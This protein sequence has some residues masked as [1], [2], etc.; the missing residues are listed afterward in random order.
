MS[1]RITQISKE[2]KVISQKMVEGDFVRKTNQ[3]IYVSQ[4]V[5]NPFS[6]ET[7]ITYNVSGVATVKFEFYDAGFKLVKEETVKV[8][9][10]GKYTYIFKSTGLADG[11]YFYRFTAGNYVE[12]K[13][14]AIVK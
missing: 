4:N 12:V 9:K 7:T 13:K 6:D 1:Y 10:E 3:K 5:P 2:H 14:M 8:P 11:I